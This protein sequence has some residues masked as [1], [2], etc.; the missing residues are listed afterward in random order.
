MGHLGH[1]KEAYRDLVERLD[2]GQVGL[3]EPEDER[4]VRGRQEILEILYEPQ[5]AAIAAKMPSR[6]SRLKKVAERVGMA[7][8]IL[9]PKLDAMCDK[10]LVMDLV[11][12]GTGEVRYFLSP[13]VVGFFEFSLMRANDGIPKKKIAEAL[14]AYT[15]HDP[16]FA[17]EVFGHETVV[18]RALT[19]EAHIIDDA[20]PD[21][22]DWE[23][24]TAIIEAS[25]TQSLSLCYCRHKAEH[26]GQACDA[27]QE[28]CLSLNAGAE[29]VIRRGF[30]RQITKEEALQVLAD[31]R[32][33]G[34]VQIAD[35][36]RNRPTYICN[37]CGCCCGQLQ[38]INEYGLAAVNP[39]GFEPQLS[40]DKCAGCPICSQA[41]PI[42]AISMVGHRATGKR[43]NTL[44]PEF[45]RETCIGCG[46]CAEACRKDALQMVRTHDQPY[47]PL[48]AVE[49]AIRQAIERGRLAHLLVD[50]GESR[51]HRFL[52][53][54]LDTLIHLPV[55]TRLL[56]G[57]Q[58]QSR[59]VRAALN[60]VKDPTGG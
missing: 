44:R 45:D 29:F 18:G 60:R 37:C 5:E 22:L 40:A 31:A 13:P 10:G 6:P 28:T 39:S 3:P 11:H 26:L 16:A 58:V 56:A 38:A 1:L 57:E 20:L 2:Q 54:V 32:K 19:R 49:K 47:V 52:N 36:V 24:A 25:S 35:N 14:H 55:A 27:P 42:S 8:E 53:Q 7:P 48:S 41:C 51:G 50:Q 33:T 21:V 17:K 46:V 4:A 59:F 23:K 43:K 12:P 34:L 15:H 30:G 9:K